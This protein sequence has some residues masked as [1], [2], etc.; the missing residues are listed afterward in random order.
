MKLN[1]WINK[2][3][4]PVLYFCCS[5]LFLS[6][7]HTFKVNQSYK[8]LAEEQVKKTV[9]LWIEKDL[10]KVSEIAKTK[11]SSFDIKTGFEEITEL[12]EILDGY[13]YESVDYKINA[14]SVNSS[15]EDSPI[16]KAKVTITNYNNLE[17][18][19]TVINQLI[20]TDIKVDI[21]YNFNDFIKENIDSIKK[22]CQSI[23]KDY[24]KVVIINFT[25]DK[26]F[27]L[28]LEDNNDFYNALSGN[29]LKFKKEVKEIDVKI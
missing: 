17:V 23:K 20:Q 6:L 12:Q 24:E 22:A 15:N 1:K 14:V 27:Y 16:V 21:N 19:K 26:Q 10:P 5:F 18:L 29:M 7:I 2:A 4:K 11:D 28:P 25:Y 3:K 8:M 13:I 9:E